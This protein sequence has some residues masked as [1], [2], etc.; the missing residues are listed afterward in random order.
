MLRRVRDPL[1]I[2]AHVYG[3][4]TSDFPCRSEWL[5]YVLME[6]T[7]DP[8][9]AIVRLYHFTPETNL[10]NIR[11]HGGI[12]ATA[13]LHEMGIEFTPGGNDLSLR[14]DAEGGMDQYVHLCWDHGHPMEYHVNNRGIRVK[15]LEIDRAVLY[16]AST[17][18]CPGVANADSMPTYSV[19]EAVDGGMIDYDA[20]NR[21][22]GPL[23]QPENQARRQKAERSEILIPDFVPMRFIRNFPNG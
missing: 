4:P 23:R 2:A 10:A 20:I 3:Q 7:P 9:L 17:L 12:Y 8:L 14:L 19:R 22:I 16:E 21:R 13:R 18:F 5:E 6:P 1:K 15:Y 11:A